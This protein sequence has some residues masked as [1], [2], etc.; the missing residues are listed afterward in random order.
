M[1]A[2]NEKLNFFQKVKLTYIY[3]S[4]SDIFVAWV[5]GILFIC[6][7]IT[8]ITKRCQKKNICRKRWR[9]GLKETI[10]LMLIRPPHLQFFEDGIKITI[11]INSFNIYPLKTEASHRKWICRCLGQFYFLKGLA[12]PSTAILWSLVPFISTFFITIMIPLFAT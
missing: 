11:D 3:S 6:H 7:T 8:I 9:G 10:E 5:L 4:C 12:D 2:S 1:P